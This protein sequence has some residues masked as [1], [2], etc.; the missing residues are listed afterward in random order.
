MFCLLA[1][2]A[3][4]A[5]VLY[6]VALCLVSMSLFLGVGRHIISKSKPFFLELD[7]GF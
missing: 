7:Q 3:K 6:C 2:L 5:E 4:M 1:I